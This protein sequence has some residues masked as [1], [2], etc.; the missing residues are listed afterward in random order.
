MKNSIKNTKNNSNVHAKEV[1]RILKANQASCEYDES[2]VP[3][4]KS[5]ISHLV[6][7]AEGDVAAAAQAVDP[8]TPEDFTP[9]QNQKDFGDSLEKETPGDNFDTE[10]TDP[11]VTANAITAIREWSKKLDDFADF[12]NNP[13]SQSLHKILAAEDRPGSLL[14]GVTRKASDSI[15]RIAGEIEKLKEVLNSFIIMAPKKQRD[16]EQTQVGN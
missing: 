11:N 13:D 12:M 10:G 7:E 14:R 6:R 15:T 16:F 2:Y 8:K 4:L 5:F 9:D 3:F 1:A